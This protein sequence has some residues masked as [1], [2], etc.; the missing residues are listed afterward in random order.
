MY[1]FK[2]WKQSEH[3]VTEF[4]STY[5]QEYWFP[6]NISQN[7]SQ[8]TVRILICKQYITK[9]K[10]TYC[11][12]YW[13]PNNIS[14]N[15]SQHTVTNTDFQT[16]YHRMQVNILSRILIS[17]QHITECKSTYCHKYWFPNNISQNA[18]QHTVKNTDFQTI[19]H[20]IKL[21]ILSENLFA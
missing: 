15:A 21:K 12:E 10:S 18:S 7:S 20:R 4:I 9:C 17:K 3:T 1:T 16:I 6:N 8:H 14:Q 13:F 2:I 5:C 19:Y 11:Q